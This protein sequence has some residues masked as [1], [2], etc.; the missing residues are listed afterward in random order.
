MRFGFGKDGSSLPAL[1]GTGLSRRVGGSSW[2][3]SCEDPGGEVL[4]RGLLLMMSVAEMIFDLAWFAVKRD[5]WSSY[6]SVVFYGPVLIE[7]S[8]SEL[9]SEKTETR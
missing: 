8:A 6:F 4:V 9:F 3:K 5:M 2:I 7:M 1:E